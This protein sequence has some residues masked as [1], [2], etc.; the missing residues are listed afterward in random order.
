MHSR[1]LCRQTAAMTFANTTELPCCNCNFQH[2]PQAKTS[3]ARKT[4]NPEV[5]K[6][7][8]LLSDMQVLVAQK[9]VSLTALLLASGCWGRVTA[10]RDSSQCPGQPLLAAC[11]AELDR[12]DDCPRALQ[13]SRT[14]HVPA[15]KN[16]HIHT[17]QHTNAI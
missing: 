1:Q 4:W 15:S 8:E 17:Q 12:L 16:T 5:P 11:I 10:A 14:C 13:H 6:F 7:N 2:I 3:N 9:H